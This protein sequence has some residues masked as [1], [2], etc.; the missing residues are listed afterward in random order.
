MNTPSILFLCFMIFC[1]GAAI[2]SI[3]ERSLKKRSTIR[4][5]LTLSN[6]KLAE[7][8][9]VEIFGAW[10]TPANQ[11]W[12]E[13]DGTRLDNKE[14]LQA[15]QRQRLLNFVLDMRPW[16]DTGRPAGVSPAGTAQ[17]VQ[18]EKNKKG[19]GNK[20]VTP[21]PV[22]ESII[23]QIDKVLQAKLA[24]SEFKDRDIQLNEGPGGI[25][26]VKDGRNNYE[27]IDAI[28]DQQVKDLIRQA[29]ADWEKGSR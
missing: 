8:G 10:R 20:E 3:V 27:G 14:A 13:M 1:L 9:D 29:V 22:L 2:G 17:V 15:G 28:P 6:N 7:A 23:Q 24:T 19:T 11:V 21:L 5:P 25:V 12:L 16:L 4:Q 26:I 18:P